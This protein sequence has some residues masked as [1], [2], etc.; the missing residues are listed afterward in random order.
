MTR[1]VDRQTL[2]RVSR[3]YY[4]LGETQ[5]S[6]AG[7][8]GV[9][10]PQVSK[11]LK[12]ARAHGV[13]EIRIVDREDR[14]TAVDRALRRRFRLRDVH[15]AP[16]F[17]GSDDHTRRRVGALAA[18]ALAA[19]VRDGMVVGVGDGSAIAAVADELVPTA[20][21]V[22]ATIVP[23]CG[24]FWGAAGGAEPYHRIADGLGAT[25][26][27]LLAPGILDDAA[28]RDALASHAGIR[29]VT[30]LW[31][32]LDVAIFGIGGPTWGTA[33]VGEPARAVLDAAGAVGEVLISPFDAAGRFIE[34][35]LAGRTIACPP[36]RLR[37]VPVAMGVA[38]GTGKVLPILGALRAGVVNTLVTDLETAAAVLARDGLEP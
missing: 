20:S 38:S 24:G 15:V 1:P 30:D 13:V 26:H 29:E 33:Q 3:M 31:R 23:L 19:T 36:A 12:Q 7:A 34:T 6:I 16:T 28:T 11:L 2:V 14:R 35:D 22:A 4:E 17:D 18:Q 27:G 32:R 37:D 21:R 9:T 8:L 25:P 5:A 10:R